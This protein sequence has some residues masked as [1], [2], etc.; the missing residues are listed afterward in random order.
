MALQLTPFS[1][2]S[3][4]PVTPT[5]APPSSLIPAINVRPSS[6]PF[7]C[8]LHIIAVPLLYTTSGEIRAATVQL[9]AICDINIVSVRRRRKELTN[10][11]T[12][13]L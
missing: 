4:A 11:E 13:W 9:Q 3:Y 5:M 2:S 1:N 12:A 7:S 10:D 6:T 8:A